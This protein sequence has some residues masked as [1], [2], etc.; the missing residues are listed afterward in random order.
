MDP[1][2]D[3][4]LKADQ[5]RIVQLRVDQVTVNPTGI[6]VDMKTDGMREYIQSVIAEPEIRKAA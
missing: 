6:R 3:E 2:W 4:L 1:E 5:V